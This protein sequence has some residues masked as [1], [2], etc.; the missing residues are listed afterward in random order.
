MSQLTNHSEILKV[1][2]NLLE[3]VSCLNH[4]H[5]RLVDWMGDDNAIVQAARVSY[6]GGTKTPEEDAKLINYLMKNLHTTPFEMVEFKFHCKMPIFIARQWIRHRTA[7][8]NEISG[9]YS[10]LADDFFI[11]NLEDIKPQSKINKQGRDE[12]GDLPKDMK[13]N[14]INQII[15]QQEKVYAF[16][17]ASVKGGMAKEMARINLPLSTFTEWY[18]KIDLHNLLHFLRLRVDNHAQKE[19]RVYGEAMASMVKKICPI[20][21]GAF[22]ENILFGQR[23]SKSEYEKLVG[24]KSKY[25]A[26]ME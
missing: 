26:Q 9:R 24:Y 3:P 7:N 1:Y 2:P 19:I 20:A 22:E 14:F 25:E 21:Y 12:D 4:G 8:V 10:Q 17:D 13:L 5:V 6:G 18:W 15:A 23:L 11:P 16:Y